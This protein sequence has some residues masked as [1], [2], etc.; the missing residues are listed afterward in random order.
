MTDIKA[1]PRTSSP[2]NA[3]GSRPPPAPRKAGTVSSTARG[4]IETHSGA[5]SVWLVEKGQNV[6][7]KLASTLS[8]RLGQK[9]TQQQLRE[10]IAAFAKANPTLKD[11]SGIVPGDRLMLPQP[12]A[13]NAGWGAKRTPT[14]TA[15]QTSPA[16]A[17]AP[18][19]G[20]AKLSGLASEAAAALCQLSP[21]SKD[22]IVKRYN[23][24]KPDDKGRILLLDPKVAMNVALLAQLPAV[25]VS[26][27]T[28]AMPAS[29]TAV[30]V[31]EIFQQPKALASLLSAAKPDATTLTAAEQ[32]TL[33]TSL[34][35][36]A[37]DKPSSLKEPA[38]RELF[39]SVLG[40]MNAD[41]VLKALAA[42]A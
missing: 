19:E 37:K 1:P 35:E 26:S 20:D 22:D 14:P 38:V 18:K 8:E 32:N 40:V 34:L 23:E 15:T 31:A 12:E 27:T 28:N 10:Y 3:F 41:R 9:P 17:P 13:V 24:L 33:T 2:A 4:P 16:A 7:A 21:K 29:P 6:S 36:L 30:D 25:K 5:G 42:K 11:L 39:K